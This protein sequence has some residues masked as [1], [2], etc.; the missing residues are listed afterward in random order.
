VIE[1]PQ[2]RYTQDN[3]TLW[4]MSVQFEASAADDVRPDQGVGGAI[5]PRDLQTGSRWAGG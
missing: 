2:L 3:Q 5:W 4:R 1:A